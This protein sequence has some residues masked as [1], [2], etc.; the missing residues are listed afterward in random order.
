M[1]MILPALPLVHVGLD[2]EANEAQKQK[3]DQLLPPRPREPRAPQRDPSAVHP[4]SWAP[5]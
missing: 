4:L 1:H 3:G 5:R 2:V